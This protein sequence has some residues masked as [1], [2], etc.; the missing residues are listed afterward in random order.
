MHMYI[1]KV[2]PFVARYAYNS[3]S[4][5][6]IGQK[7]PLNVLNGIKFCTLWKTHYDPARH[8][9]KFQKCSLSNAVCCKNRLFLV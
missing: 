8:V 4:K 9:P 2:T 1:C 6:R 5:Y 7:F 3:I